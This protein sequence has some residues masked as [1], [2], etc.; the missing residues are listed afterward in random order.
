[1]LASL[2]DFHIMV[3]MEKVSWCVSLSLFIF[4]ENERDG[5]EHS[6][7]GGDNGESKLVFVLHSRHEA[8]VG[9]KRHAKWLVQVQLEQVLA[10][11]VVDLELQVHCEGQTTRGQVSMGD[12][13]SAC[14]L[15]PLYL[16]DDCHTKCHHHHPVLIYF[17]QKHTAI[18]RTENRWLGLKGSG[19]N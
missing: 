13:C 14:A 5:E 12:P 1:M 18:K 2:L 8:L 10:Q 16:P 7:A 17:A 3:I 4:W 9:T 15:C 6:R 19:C 11:L